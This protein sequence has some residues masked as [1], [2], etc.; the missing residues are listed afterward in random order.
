MSTIPYNFEHT[1]D[2][3]YD[4]WHIYGIPYYAII[5]WIAATLLSLMDAL[6]L[7]SFIRSL[8]V[9]NK[10]FC[11]KDNDKYINPIQHEQL[12]YIKIFSC[13]YYQ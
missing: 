12:N 11:R 4:G 10:Y 7:L 13:I 3:V 6:L 2:D 8:H 5:N 1:F 9:Y